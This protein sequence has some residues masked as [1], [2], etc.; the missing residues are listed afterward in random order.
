MKIVEIRLGIFVGNS[1][2]E[3]SVSAKGFNV[4]D[5]SFVGF[6]YSYTRPLVS[7]AISDFWISVEL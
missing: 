4:C 7:R 6:V 1:P 2:S 3:K 5:R